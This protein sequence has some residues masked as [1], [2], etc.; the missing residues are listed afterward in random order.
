MAPE[1]AEQGREGPGWLTDRPGV[2]LREHQGGSALR[3]V[4]MPMH[5]VVGMGLGQDDPGEGEALK[6]CLQFM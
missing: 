1:G 4:S 2:T 3:V 6:T 5:L